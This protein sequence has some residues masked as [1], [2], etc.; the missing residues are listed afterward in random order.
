MDQFS[1]ARLR[2]AMHRGS[3]GSRAHGGLYQGSVGFWNLIMGSDYAS[4]LLLFSKT[5]CHPNVLE[6]SPEQRVV[7]FAGKMCRETNRELFPNPFSGAAAS[8]ARVRSSLV[9]SGGI[10]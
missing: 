6:N 8:K 2:R 4:A 3:E 10:N 5:V 1:K 7:G 9:S